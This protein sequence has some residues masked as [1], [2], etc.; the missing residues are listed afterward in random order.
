MVL[1][2]GDDFDVV[3]DIENSVDFVEL[4]VDVDV[5]LVIGDEDDVASDVE[6]DLDVLERKV[7]VRYG[8]N[9]VTDVEEDI[10]MVEVAVR[11]GGNVDKVLAGVSPTQETATSS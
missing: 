7:E 5:V 6:E 8:R 9:V 1:D 10:D 11:E 4:T 2:D 3:F